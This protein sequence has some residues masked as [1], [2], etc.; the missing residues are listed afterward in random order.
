VLIKSCRLKSGDDELFDLRINDETI[1]AIEPAKSVRLFDQPGEEIINASGALLTSSLAEPHAHLDKAFLSERIANPT[2]DL[3]GAINAMESHRNQITVADTIER[4]ER[5]VRLMVRNGVTAIRTHADV[6]EWNSL[7]SVEALLEVRSRTK[8]IVDLQI[9]ALLGWPL[10]GQDGKANLARG[11]AA[12]KL[13]VDLLGGCPHLDVDAVGANIALLELASEL[14]CGLDL[15]T[16]EHTDVNRISLED[17][18]ERVIATGFSNSVTASHC[19]S[20]GMQNSET[21]KRICEKVATA[22]IGVVTLPHTNLFLQSRDKHTAPP[23]GLTAISALRAAGVRVAA[24]ADNL[25]DPFNPIGRGD[26]LESAALLILAAHQLPNEAFAAVSSTAKSVMGL[27]FSEIKIGGIADL[28]LTPVHSI[29][30]AIATAE[31]RSMVMRR[32][33]VTFSYLAQPKR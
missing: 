24:G 32:G 12:I 5:A 29:R 6:T 11:K 4:A 22:N 28:M 33:K 1:V 19:V 23:R 3:M 17:L 18:A 26:P 13:G 16:D 27:S 14:G 7:D 15:H 21:Q 10:S 30:E 8:D 2:G 31:P 25:Q 9:C 20:L